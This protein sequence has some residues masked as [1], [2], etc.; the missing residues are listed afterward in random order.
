MLFPTDDL[1]DLLPARP[2]AL[3]AADAARAPVAAVHRRRELRL[4]RLVGLA[5]RLPARAA[6]SLGNQ[7]LRRRGSTARRRPQPAKGAARLAVAGNL[8]V[9]GYFKY[10]DFFVSSTQNLLTLVGLDAPARRARRSSCRSAS[11][12]SRSWRSATSSTSTAAT[13]S[14]VS[15]EKFAAYL[16]FFPHLVAGPIVRAERAHAAVRRAARPA[17]GRHG[18]AFFLIATGLFK[19][20]VIAN[21]LAVEHRRRGLRRARP[22][23]VARDPRRRLRL[24]G[25]DLRRLLRL[26]RHRDRPRA[27]ARLPLPAELRLARTRPSSL[28]DFWRRWHMT[29]SRWLRDYLYIPLGGSRGGELHDVPQPHADDAARRPLAR[30]GVDVR[31]LGRAST[32]S[33]SSSSAGGAAR[34]RLPRPP[35]HRRGAPWRRLVTFHFVCF[36][37]IFFR[38]DS[39]ADRLGPARPACSRAGASRSPLV[40]SASCSRSPSGSAPSTC[41]RAPP[42]SWRASRASPVAQ[43][44]V[45]ALALMSRTP[46]AREGVAPFIYFRF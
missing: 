20:V 33:G 43:G 28:Q 31:G 12:S 32:A 30:R 4:L 35:R 46:W 17:P 21:Y 9:L 44:R 36:A 34:P 14:R 45:L 26:H 24:R 29:L 39:F 15:L 18:R 41:R 7:V 23:L 27:A 22:A 16:S 10:Y 19:K 1:R 40:T 13:S 37:W 38:A 25:P 8:G 5:L 3:V 2:A 42:A 11:R 6:R